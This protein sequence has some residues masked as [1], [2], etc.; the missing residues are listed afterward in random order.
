V[1]AATNRNLPSRVS[2]GT[3]RDD[4]YFRL[5]V[6]RLTIP[7]L[8]ER[9]QDIPFLVEHFVQR[10]NARRGKRVQGV[11]PSVMEILMRHPLPGNVRELENII[12]YSFAFCHNGLIDVQH[13]PDDLQPDGG[14]RSRPPT[15][16]TYSPLEESEADVIRAALLENEGN[17]AK[18]AE[19]LRISRTTLW[20]KMRRYG[21]MADGVHEAP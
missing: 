17:R 20:R 13:L 4:L 19:S 8:A 11:T 21:I 15:P 3:F 6:V 10:F 18:T 2:Q 16:S 9:R 14:G 7:P 12:E 5:A 1:V